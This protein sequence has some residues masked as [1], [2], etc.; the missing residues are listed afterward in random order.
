MKKLL[1]M[2]LC[3]NFSLISYAAIDKGN[4]GNECSKRFSH[5]GRVIFEIIANDE[6]YKERMDIKKL[7]DAINSAYVIVVDGPL[8][9][10]N[11]GVVPAQNDGKSIITLSKK[12]WCEAMGYVDPSIVL[13]EYLGISEP[14]IDFQYQI[15]GTLFSQTGLG[16]DDF[17]NYYNSG[18]D[19]KIKS[20]TFN[21]PLELTKDAVTIETKSI[22][23][24]FNII[25]ISES[26]RH[27]F[28]A[29]I[30]CS[31]ADNYLKLFSLYANYNRQN[32]PAW[33]YEEQ[34]LESFKF[35]N[36]DQCKRF[37]NQAKLIGSEGLKV[38]LG[39][40]SL[41]VLNF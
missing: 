16:Y 37:L 33:F 10:R 34:F 6:F 4:G 22:K 31:T 9:D 13:H 18:S 1:L 24:Y 14:G 3:L 21:S 15:S 20:V 41:Y 5:Y 40:D 7:N 35:K 23:E 30:N 25:G 27:G 32:S 29:R 26:G 11:G 8:H 17:Y 38:E 39:L 19:F 2:L 28:R 36:A 12:E